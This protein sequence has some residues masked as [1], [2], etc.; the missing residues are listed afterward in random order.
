[1]EQTHRLLRVWGS[2]RLLED[3]Q[4]RD[5]FQFQGLPITLPVQSTMA[6]QLEG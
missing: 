4:R 5:G 1:M 6:W 2:Q 3:W